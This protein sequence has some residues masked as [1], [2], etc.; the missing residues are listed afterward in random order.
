VCCTIV[1]TTILLGV[2]RHAARLARGA[3][4]PGERIVAQSRRPVQKSRYRP[5]RMVPRDV[6]ARGARIR[7]VEAGPG[8][9]GPSGQEAHAPTLVLVHDALAS[10]DTFDGCF[11]ELA[12]SFHVVAPDLPGFGKSEKPDPE[13]FAYGF[14]GFADALFDLVAALGLGRVHVL[15][16]GMGGSVALTLA[17][18]HPSLV[19][20]LVLVDAL[21][22][23]TA[24]HPLE[25]AGRV[26]VLGGVLWRQLVGPA[27][28]RTFALGSV[29]AGASK[30]HVPEGRISALYE[31]FNSPAARQ[32]ALATLVAISDTRP[33]VARL[34]RVSAETLV[35]W[36]RD[37]RLAPVEHGRRIAREL[38]GRFEVLECGRCPPD[39]M[40]EAFAATVTSFLAS[41]PPKQSDGPPSR[42]SRPLARTALS[43]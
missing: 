37:D 41:S 4:E 21:V 36:G 1:T 20:K 28:F 9:S 24:E 5:R 39:E 6:S 33:L 27:L 22:Y 19:H 16:H 18:R 35:V 7:F 13:R 14:D 25:R 43:D 38:R 10:R 12:R 3:L 15:G 29:Y 26:P 23:P 17:A 31:G 34:P 42:R 2:T 8:P 11:D 40:P 32:A 30:E